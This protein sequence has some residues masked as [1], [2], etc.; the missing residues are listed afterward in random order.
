MKKV[1]RWRYYCDHCKKSGGS[2][3]H[4]KNHEEICTA[5]PDRKCGFCRI[6]DEVQADIKDLKNVILKNVD[7]VTNENIGEGEWWEFSGISMESE[8]SF[9]NKQKE[10]K[11]TDVLKE[12]REVANNC[13]ACILS[14]MRQTQTTFLF[15]SF[16]FKKEKESMYKDFMSDQSN[17]Y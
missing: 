2:G 8:F 9:W 17:Y 13:P 11:E 15:P 4:M 5:N 14:A 6:M 3:G 7:K 12:L 10:Q 16:D 1:K